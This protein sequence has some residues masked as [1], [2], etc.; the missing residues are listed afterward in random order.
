LTAARVGF[1]LSSDLTAAARM[2]STETASTSP[3]PPKERLRDLLA[4]SVSEEYFA[5]RKFLGLELM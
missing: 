1:L 5:A 4:Y 2:I 3:L